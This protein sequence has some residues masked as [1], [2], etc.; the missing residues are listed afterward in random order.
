MFCVA[1]GEA[2]SQFHHHSNDLG[3]LVAGFGPGAGD[4]E[5][6]PCARFFLAQLRSFPHSFEDAAALEGT[7]VERLALFRKARDEI[8]TYFGV[9]LALCNR[10]F[11]RFYQ[12]NAHP[13]TST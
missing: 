9:S 11:T 10:L 2:D 12:T 8:R 5:A 4:F 7:E 3:A 6:A 13:Q 1:P